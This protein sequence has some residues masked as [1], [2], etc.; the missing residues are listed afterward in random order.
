MNNAS[1]STA[2]MEQIES[3]AIAEIARMTPVCF[4][5]LLS[6]QCDQAIGDCAPED[7][8]DV[9]IEP[10]SGSMLCRDK[11]DEIQF[12]IL[13]RLKAGPRRQMDVRVHGVH[14][15]DVGVSFVSIERAYDRQ[16]TPGPQFHERAPAA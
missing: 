15:D 12:S 5:N 3:A 14:D 11:H 16:G 8:S 13:G 4:Q 9:S 10:L 7:R 6:R 1:N 2:T